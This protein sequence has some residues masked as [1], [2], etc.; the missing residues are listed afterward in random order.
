LFLL[1]LRATHG[2]PQCDGDRRRYWDSYWDA[3]AA[4]VGN[5]D[6]SGFRLLGLL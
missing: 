6:A 2:N 3:V 1:L 5:A 4:A